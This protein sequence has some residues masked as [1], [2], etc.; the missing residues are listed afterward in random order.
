MKKKIIEKISV[1]IIMMLM[2]SSVFGNITADAGDF[3]DIENMALEEIV[4]YVSNTSIPDPPDR[5]VGE[6]DLLPVQQPKSFGS[7]PLVYE[8]PWAVHGIDDWIINKGGTG[9]EAHDG[10]SD[11]Y[12][13][14]L[15]IYTTAELA[16]WAEVTGYSYQG[17]AFNPPVTDTYTIEYN[18]TVQGFIQGS[19]DLLSFGVSEGEVALFFKT[20]SVSQ[21]EEIIS[22]RTIPLLIFEYD[23]QFYENRQIV[24]EDDMSKGSFEW[25][26][27]EAG[28]RGTS[29]SS[30]TPWV[31]SL[32]ALDDVSEPGAFDGAILN[33]IIIDWPNHPPETP[34]E[35]DGPTEGGIGEE[36]TYS[37]RAF[38]PDDFGD[39]LW[40]KWD[41]GDEISD[42]IGP[43]CPGETVEESHI[44]NSADDYDVK[45]KV[46]DTYNEESDWSPAL[47]VTITDP[48]PNNPPYEP[49]NPYP[50]DGG[51][52]I[53]INADL[54]WTGGDP[55]PGD[56]V[57]Y[58]VY[59]GTTNPPPQVVWGQSSTSYEP[60]TMSYYTHYYW[61]II[62]TDNHGAST[63]SNLWDFTTE[64][65]S[66]NEPP[67]LYDA[68]VFPT[69]GH[70]SNEFHYVVYYQ[71]SDGDYP[72]VFNQELYIDNE[73]FLMWNYGGDPVQ[74][75][76]FFHWT[77]PYDLSAGDHEFYFKFNDGH[78][79]EVRY[80][81]SGS[82]SGPF[83]FDNY[84]PSLSNGG[85]SPSSGD[86][87]ELFTYEVKYTDLDGDP[88]TIKKVYIDDTSHTMSLYSG[89]YETGAIFRYQTT[90]PPGDH[91]Y[92]FFFNDGHDHDVRLP[93]SGTYYGPEVYPEGNQPPNIPEV[94]V[95]PLLLEIFQSGEY[96]TSADD[97][98]GHQV[99]YRFDWDA[100][101][102]YHQYSDW[103]ELDYSGHIGSVSHSWNN[104]GTYVVKAQARDKYRF[105]SE[106]SDGIIVDIT[107]EDSW[108]MTGHDPS[109][110][111]Y[112]TSTAPNTN[113]VSWSYQDLKFFESW[114]FDSPVIANNRVFVTS[115]GVEECIAG[116]FCLDADP[117]DDDI[118]EGEIDPPGSLYDI[119]WSLSD[120]N[121]FYVGKPI[122]I[123]DYVIFSLRYSGSDA[124]LK[125]LDTNTGSEIWQKPVDF[126]PY[127]TAGGKIF[128]I[129]YGSGVSYLNCLNVSNGDI[130][131]SANLNGSPWAIPAV[132]DG[133]LYVGSDN[134][135]YCLDA[136]GNGDGTTDVIWTYTMGDI[137]SISIYSGKVYVGFG[138]K[139]Y[140]LDADG[141]GDGT[142]DLIWSFTVDYMVE[143]S[144]AIAYGKVYFGAHDYSE[145]V[146]KIY[147]LDAEGNGDGTTNVIWTHDFPYCSN[148]NFFLAVSDEKVFISDHKSKLYCLDAIGNGD[149]T[150]NLT[151]TYSSSSGRFES[152]PAIYEGKIYVLS[153]SRLHCIEDIEGN[154]R[155][156]IPPAPSGPTEG[157]PIKRYYYSSTTFDMDG[158]DIYYRFDWDDGEITDW[159]GP[160]SSG[161]TV[162]ANHRW[163]QSG[164]YRVKVQAKDSHGAL[165]DW[166]ITLDYPSGVSIYWGH[167][168]PCFLAGTKITM[169]DGSYKNIEDIV[170]GD[171][172]L[173]IDRLNDLTNSVMVT[174]IYHHFPNEMTDYYM[175]INDDLRVTPN[176][177]LFINGLWK[178]AEIAAVGNFLL[179]ADGQ[180]IQIETIERVYE[181]VPTYNFEIEASA[182]IQGTQTYFAQDVLVATK[183]DLINLAFMEIMMQN[184]LLY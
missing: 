109:H 23:R 37:T 180:P 15:T 111:C 87:N 102:I 105:E 139:L 154:H 161:E 148:F 152:S 160:V 67:I 129:K 27:V 135:L 97:P 42:W 151:W 29:I 6:L 86:T 117:F 78:G 91:E 75:M 45:V 92:Y 107:G 80:P 126:A 36:Y 168:Q 103:T 54:S 61:K 127:T 70:I 72:P 122:V 83:V 114:G 136:E 49:T 133:K 163:T 12:Q 171:V 28:L 101:G 169:A 181:Q 24:I 99:Q 94:P 22:D 179:G 7:R 44:W 38:D 170:M 21:K 56:T 167:P 50:G 69:S 146:D 84:L 40:Y 16:G 128:G 123:G 68:S 140:C 13:S 19:I 98:E 17:I 18:F 158:D 131:W 120:E 30:G 156:N 55:D 76:Q 116:I 62:A 4:T 182:G 153:Q 176:H 104:P 162:E 177:P 81:E 130:I 79:H 32:G 73:R 143:T 47:T 142:T 31:E 132:F 10:G 95:G 144:A 25:I 63:E 175:I 125:C 173:S 119:I 106:W 53:S 183:N 59:F 93:S 35:P 172:V 41:W 137:D 159:I 147:C 43:F 3:P 8:A 150:T 64:I 149:G 48:P 71:D 2:I 58:D 51:T 89:D 164:Y 166:S 77:D 100:E 82:F 57:T 108:S 157:R 9:F 85:V 65:D 110:S 60:D 113:Y 52:D 5:F 121:I 1:I 134:M 145:Y 155:P 115:H 178:H 66:N 34:E 138:N 11:S 118:D 20:N 165:S 88:P 14:W 33:N 26:E 112:S 46:K 39:S 184:H 90:L 174:K 74:G 124:T 96:M 141:N